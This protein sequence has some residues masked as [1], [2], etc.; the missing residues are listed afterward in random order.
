MEFSVEQGLANFFLPDLKIPQGA[1]VSG[2][3][4][5]T[6]NN[7][8]LNVEAAQLVYRMKNKKQYTQAEQVLSDLGREYSMEDVFQPDEN[9]LVDNVVVRINTAELD[10]QIFARVDRIQLNEQVVR[11]LVLTGRNENNQ[12]LHLST[13]FLHGTREQEIAQELKSYAI[14]LNQTTNSRGDYVVQ[15][16]PTE[17]KIG[18]VAWRV[19]TSQNLAIRSPTVKARKTSLSRTCASIRTR[20]RYCLSKLL[21]NPQRTSLLRAVYKI[22]RLANFWK[23]KQEA[24]AW[25]SKELLMESLLSV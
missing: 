20:V 16:E 6:S 12:R 18:S 25:I 14:N 1:R 7:L 3:Y 22:S 5:G 21:S 15:F 17:I 19:D 13:N 4:E 2:S 23:C 8:V 24:T 11:D 10:E 9:V